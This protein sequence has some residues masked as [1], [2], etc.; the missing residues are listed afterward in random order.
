MPDRPVPGRALVTRRA[1]EEIVRAAA[2][3][4][5]GVTSLADPDLPSRIGRWLH[6]RS[7]GVRVDLH[8]G[9]RAE[10]F[11]TVAYGVPVAEVSRQVESAVRYALRR[12]LGVE[13]DRLVVHI[14]GLRYQPAR[15]P[16]ATVGTPLDAAGPVLDAEGPALDAEPVAEDADGVAATD[17][18]AGNATER[19][20]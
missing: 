13:L 18:S 11:L 10:L 17:R 14:G 15:P 20:G 19:G 1:V 12:S 3:E 6:L 16:A 8:D 5:Y 2:L 7:S 9:I 4:S